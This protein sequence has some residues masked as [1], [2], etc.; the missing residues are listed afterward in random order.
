VVGQLFE[1]QNTGNEPWDAQIDIQTLPVKST[2]TAEHLDGP[3]IA[4][5]MMRVDR[6]RNVYTVTR[7]RPAGSAPRKINRGSP[8]ASVSAMD[9][10]SGSSSESAASANRTPC[11][12]TFAAAFWPDPSRNPPAVLYVQMY[13]AVNLRAGPSMYLLPAV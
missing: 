8:E 1:L 7:T 6:P 5:A 2:S 3:D 10:P 9:R 12:L 11:F 13:T 4:G